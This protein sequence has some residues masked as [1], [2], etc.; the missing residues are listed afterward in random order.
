MQEQW[1]P[2][3]QVPN[4]PVSFDLPEGGS[5]S[6]KNSDGKYGGMM[7]LKKGLALSVNSITAFL[8]S[9]IVASVITNVVLVDV[10]AID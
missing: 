2:C 6:P 1:S 7:T 4:I 8:A 3:Y 10:S 9:D 5:W